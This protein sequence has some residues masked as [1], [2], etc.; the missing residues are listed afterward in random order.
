MNFWL[1]PTKDLNVAVGGA[2]TM[3]KGDLRHFH[4]IMFEKCGI[5]ILSN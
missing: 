2:L 4:W 1:I 5:N 3:R